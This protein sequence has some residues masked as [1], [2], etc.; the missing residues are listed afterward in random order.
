MTKQ[1]SSVSSSQVNIW[2][3]KGNISHFP[4][5]SC[6]RNTNVHCHCVSS[7][8]VT[9]SPD[10][11]RPQQTS[12]HYNSPLIALAGVGR[13]FFT[14]SILQD[15]HYLYSRKSKGN[16]SQENLDGHSSLSSF[17]TY[18]E[19]P[20]FPFAGNEENATR[21]QLLPFANARKISNFPGNIPS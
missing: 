14:D 20:M 9:Y 3:K 7:T 12:Q 17:L 6:L 15:S 13:P 1:G 18:L 21:C 8:L 5:K 16:L 10:V 19:I 11:R 4:S 2:L